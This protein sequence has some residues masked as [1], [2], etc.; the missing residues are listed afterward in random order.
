MAKINKILFKRSK[1]AGI[2]PTPAS[3]SEGE[4]FINL[5]DRV[6][7]TKSGTNLIDLGFA[8][9]GNVDGNINQTSGNFVTKGTISDGSGRVFSPGN[10]PSWNQVLGL[11]DAVKEITNDVIEFNRTIRSNRGQVIAYKNGDNNKVI[12]IDYL[13]KDYPTIITRRGATSE[14]RFLTVPDKSGT[15]ALQEDNYTKTEQDN[16]YIRIGTGGANPAFKYAAGGHGYFEWYEGGTRQAIIGFPSNGTNHFEIR[17]EKPNGSINF[18]PAGNGRITIKGVPVV[19][20]GQ[21][22]F[23]GGTSAV[24]WN[25]EQEFLNAARD[26]KISSRIFR[27]DQTTLINGVTRYTPA[28]LFKAGDTWA[29][30]SIDYSTGRL[31]TRGG[32]SSGGITSPT[33][34]YLFSDEV[35]TRAEADNRFLHLRY[36]NTLG[37]PMRESYGNTV[38]NTGWV[39][40]AEIGDGNL[41]NSSNARYLFTVVSTTQGYASG[42]VTTGYMQ[43]AVTIL[44]G[45]DE[46]G[47][48]FSVNVYN[49]GGERLVRVKQINS[50]KAEIW[51]SVGSYSKIVT[52]CVTTS[53]IVFKSQVMV[54]DL[55]LGGTGQA[56]TYD[57][58]VHYRMA[59]R[60]WTTGTF[61]SK[62]GTSDISGELIWDKKA[63]TT[64]A[65]YINSTSDDATSVNYMRRFRSQ[66][67]GTLY[68][69]VAEQGG[70]AY[71]SGS[72]PTNFMSRLNNGGHLI[73]RDGLTI[74]DTITSS[75]GIHTSV[76]GG[77]FASWQTRGA[78]LRVTA[79]DRNGASSIFK[80]VDGQSSTAI[81][82]FDGY[83]TDG[84]LTGSQGRLVVGSSSMHINQSE[85]TFNKS[86]KTSGDMYAT[87][88]V[89][90]GANSKKLSI[91]TAEDTSNYIAFF[92]KSSTSDTNRTAYV[93]FPDSNNLNFT[94]RNDKTSTQLIVSS[95]LKFGNNKVLDVSDITQSTGSSTTLVPSQAIV[96]NWI[97]DRYNKGESDSR[98]LRM[99]V[100]NK[101]S[102]PVFYKTANYMDYAD[103]RD[104]NYAGFYRTNR[105]NGLPELMIHVPH[106]SGLAHGRGIGFDYGST[107]YGIYTYAYDGTGKYLGTKSIAL[108]ENY[109]SKT[110]SDDR[111]YQKSQTYTKA[112]VDSRVNV[113]ANIAD[114]YAKS[115]VYQK[116][117][118]YSRAE[119]DS[120]VNVKANIADVYAKSQTYTKSEVDSKI[121]SSGPPARKMVTLRD[122]GTGDYSYTN[123]TGYDVV[124]YY[125]VSVQSN[126][127]GTSGYITMNGVMIFSVPHLASLST[128]ITV[129]VPPG[130]KSEAYDFRGSS[131]SVKALVKA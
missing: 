26:Q 110:V 92:N 54:N 100:V 101:T 128:T 46:P 87:T 126:P 37:V 38:G 77:S 130:S 47:K 84:S 67:N 60:N 93:G 109:Y 75:G 42:T 113:K 9:G 123:N 20:E 49:F 120:R 83:S 127:N 111:Y 68:H 86:I 104:L 62:T 31:T 112:E 81:I 32:N 124:L 78:G 18:T 29:N 16:R 30:L 98:Y 52:S 11:K 51:V 103:Q 25:N 115:A 59:D 28:F 114:V 10:Q 88:M 64:Y 76:K 23:H 119:V 108:S 95:T 40:I 85:F 66:R 91:T 118:T 73:L 50:A 69:E 96:T 106:S 21:D 2:R 44:N 35:W 43:I 107:G 57:A 17:N 61:L 39:C 63:P 131:F 117:E 1:T 102:L 4:L 58:Q 3:M 116:T 74:Q 41:N 82:A 122:G 5:A 80:M 48:N 27:N 71:Y 65:Q 105:L 36:A 94:I 97:N 12:G 14:W 33:R 19:V 70:L 121:A 72:T 34:S 56:T 125:A 45:N 6:L 90:S 99:N 129:V 89:L 55:P 13:N 53:P 15:V 7:L 79:T 8:K 24:R 22:G